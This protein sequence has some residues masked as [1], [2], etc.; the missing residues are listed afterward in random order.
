MTEEQGTTEQTVREKS[1]TEKNLDEAASVRYL[2]T[3]DFILFRTP[4][5]G[6]RLTLKGDRSVLRIKARRCFP[7]SMP[8]KFISLRDGSDGEIGI[9][10]DLKDL[11]NDYRR[12]IE[13]DLEM[14]YYV[15][16]VRSIKTIRQ[17]FGGIEWHVDTDRGPKR[18]ITKGVHDTMMEVEIGR[19]IVTDVDGNRFEIFTDR[20]DPASS[21]WLNRLI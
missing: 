17:R 19:F 8:D 13:E 6:M 7:Y 11:P 12:W 4:A 5:G 14:R 18:L 1:E 10:A 20:L 21:E 16:Q 2:T 9:I 15:P 3:D